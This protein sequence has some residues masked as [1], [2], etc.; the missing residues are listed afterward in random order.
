MAY[1]NISPIGANR[2]WP[3]NARY[4]LSITFYRRLASFR[5]LKYAKSQPFISINAPLSDII[6]GI[7]R[8]KDVVRIQT[9]TRCLTADMLIIMAMV[10]S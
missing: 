2:T 6:A 3:E 1:S 7:I 10:N 5:V 9:P 4:D 8:R